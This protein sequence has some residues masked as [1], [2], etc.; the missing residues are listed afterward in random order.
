[1]SVQ[2]LKVVTFAMIDHLYQAFFT[3]YNNALCGDQIRPTICDVISA[4]NTFDIHGIRYRRYLR[5]TAEQL[6]GKPVMSDSL[7]VPAYTR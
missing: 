3:K 2:V 6:L 7:Q 4:I 5:K 1:M